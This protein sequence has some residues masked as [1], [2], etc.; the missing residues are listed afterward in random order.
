M[1]CGCLLQEGAQP[2][3]DSRVFVMLS[4]DTYY[5]VDFGLLRCRWSGLDRVSR[6]IQLRSL[7]EQKPRKICLSRTWSSTEGA[8]PAISTTYVRRS[9]SAPPEYNPG[10]R[11]RL[12]V[13][14]VV[15]DCHYQLLCIAHEAWV[16]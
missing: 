6:A 14:I 5:R 15:H 4:H 11:V 13:R 10:K 16:S 3:A 7:R 2:H 1:S 12:R 9:N 8:L